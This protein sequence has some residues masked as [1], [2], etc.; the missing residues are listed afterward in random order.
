MRKILIG[1]LLVVLMFSIDTALAET[2]STWKEWGI[3]LIK[4]TVPDSEYWVSPDDE[5]EG[6]IHFESQDLNFEDEMEIKWQGTSSLNYPKKN[7]TVK[8]AEGVDAGWGIQKKYC[9][10]AN[11]IDPTHA[12]NIVANRL[13]AQMNKQY[14]K[15]V[16]SPNFGQIDGFPVMV[17]LNDQ[18]QG[19]YTFNIPKAAWTFAMD[20][21][22]PDH[23]AIQGENNQYYFDKLPEFEDFEVEVGDYDMDRSFEIFLRLAD[24]IV[25]CSVE[26]FREHA[27]EYLD[28]DACINYYCF[29]IANTAI[30]NWQKNMIF[31]TYDG[32]LWTPVLYDMDTLW[33]YSWDGKSHLQAGHLDVDDFDKS[34]FWYKLRA[35]YGQE[36]KERYKELRQGVLS[37]ENM[38]ACFEAFK[39]AIPL[40]CYEADQA[41]W[42]DGQVRTYEGTYAYMKDNLA[43]IDVRMEEMAD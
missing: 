18:L 43:W 17:E 30:D 41:L 10:K 33:G 7:F 2:E 14:G 12:C 8:I 34:Q 15:F 16:N 35:A 22:N 9:L 23:I 13:A 26:E 4:L 21:E 38:V 28:I 32:R 19:L 29:A 40:K 3:P 6:T 20:D 39:M 11:Y 36:I 31:A 24:F 5:F 42:N 37:Y 1:L 25:N 27:A